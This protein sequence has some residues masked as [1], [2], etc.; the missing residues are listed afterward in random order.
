M[1]GR[2]SDKL[3]PHNDLC[4]DIKRKTFR[5]TLLLPPSTIVGERGAAKEAAKSEHGDKLFIAHLL[6]VPACNKALRLL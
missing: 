3:L 4:A 5:C 2:V 6:P 1:S